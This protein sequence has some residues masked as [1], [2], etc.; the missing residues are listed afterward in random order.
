MIQV[1]RLHP[2]ARLP[3]TRHERS[4]T[5]SLYAYCRTETGRPNK[6]LI[7]PYTTRSIPT[8]LIVVPPDG[9]LI[10]LSSGSDL[11]ASRCLLV[12]NA[13]GIVDPDYR[14][15]LTVYL[16]NGGHESHYISHDD[17]IGEM[18]LLVRGPNKIEEI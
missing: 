10:A 16:Y 5:Y 3:T 15:E 11:A 18:F 2:D 17:Y 9:W 14:G 13:P 4:I 12:A 7:P 6:L 1:K 8:G